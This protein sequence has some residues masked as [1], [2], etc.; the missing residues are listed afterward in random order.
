VELGLYNA[1]ESPEG[2]MLGCLPVLLLVALRDPLHKRRAHPREEAD[3]VLDV[4]YD[5]HDRKSEGQRT[6]WVHRESN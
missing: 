2:A 6:I 1:G 5:R 4:K 3:D